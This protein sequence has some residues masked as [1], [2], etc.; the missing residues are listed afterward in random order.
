LK[1]RHW[2]AAFIEALHAPL[3][4]RFSRFSRPTLACPS[5]RTGLAAMTKA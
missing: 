3:H 1:P 5:A 4:S 2:R